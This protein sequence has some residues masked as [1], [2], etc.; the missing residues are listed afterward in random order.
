MYLTVLII[1]FR[2]GKLLKIS[3]N[4]DILRG[5]GQQYCMFFGFEYTVECLIWR[6]VQRIKD[7]LKHPHVGILEAY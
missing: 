2:L 4:P 1:E 7:H 3:Y 5:W 6:T